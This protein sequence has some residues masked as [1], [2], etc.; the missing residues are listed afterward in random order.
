MNR[1]LWF[2]QA[3]LSVFFVL[4]SGAPKLLLPPETLPMPIPLPYSFVLFI[5]VAEVF[6]GLGLIVPA[7][8]GVRPG[9]VP[10]AAS[11]LVLVTLGA[12]AYQLAA[13]EVAAAVFPVAVGL[14]CAFVAYGRWQL[15]PLR[16]SRRTVER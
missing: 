10:L 13:G 2:V 3:L 14:L 16:G 9:L 15:A 6:G 1:A 12:T 5:G 4:A 7:I 11:G 8:D